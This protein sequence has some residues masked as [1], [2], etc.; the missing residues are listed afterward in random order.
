MSPAIA[1][2]G[3]IFSCMY[4][5]TISPSQLFRGAGPLARGRPQVGLLEHSKSRTKLLCGAANHGRGRHL[6]AA[7]SPIRRPRLQEDEAR[8]ARPFIA[9]TSRRGCRFEPGS[10]PH[11]LLC[12]PKSHARDEDGT[13]Q[14][15]SLASPVCPDPCPV[16]RRAAG[17]FQK[18]VVVRS[19]RAIRSA[20]ADCGTSD[21]VSAP[22]G[23][24]SPSWRP[25]FPRSEWKPERE[26]LGAV[27]PVSE[28]AGSLPLSKCQSP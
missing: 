16:C 23:C 22:R 13:A 27:Q 8:L 24:S 1:A 20:R 18:P 3:D 4:Y 21:N 7:Q 14:A 25:P 2:A 17:P 5:Y 9:R 19:S 11:S 10:G 28:T 6:G 12:R 26:G 15:F